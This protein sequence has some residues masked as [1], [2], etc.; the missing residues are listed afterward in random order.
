MFVEIY[1][2]PESLFLLISRV[3]TLLHNVEDQKGFGSFLSDC[4]SN[5]SLF[6]EASQLELAICD[7]KNECPDPEK[8]TVIPYCDSCTT[9]PPGESYI[10]H[11]EAMALMSL[12]HHCREAMH[13]A[14]LIYFYRCIRNVDTY[15]LQ[16]YV[17]KTAEHLARYAQQKQEISDLSSNVCWPGFIA[18]CEAVDPEMRQRFSTWFS[19]E[20]TIKGIR[21][22]SIAGQAV[23][24]VWEARDRT[25]NR[26]LPWSQVLRENSTLDQL[27][28]G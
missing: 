21:M 16:P 12:V 8:T 26:N 23:Q 5:S 28:L 13:C 3:T 9:E 20:T 24:Q 14:L 4:D 1:S 15:M 11:A 18:G 19:S 7:W 17:S 6:A 27:V 22:F 25:K 10:E 2:L